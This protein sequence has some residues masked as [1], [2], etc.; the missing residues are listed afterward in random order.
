MSRIIGKAEESLGRITDN[1]RL[2][3]KGHERRTHA[4]NKKMIAKDPATYLNRVNDGVKDNYDAGPADNKH[5]YQAVGRQD[6]PQHYPDT[7]QPRHTPSRNI[8]GHKEALTSYPTEE[9]SY[10]AQH[11]P[12]VDRAEYTPR[13]DIADQKETTPGY[14][15]NGQTHGAQDRPDA[16]NSQYLPNHNIA[17]HQEA[18]EGYPVRDQKHDVQHHLG[19]NKPEQ[20]RSHDFADQGGVSKGY[21]TGGQSY[22]MQR[23]TDAGPAPYTEDYAT[24]NQHNEVPASSMP[25]PPPGDVYEV[26]KDAAGYNIGGNHGYPAANQHVE[27]HNQRNSEQFQQNRGRSSASD[28]ESSG[29]SKGVGIGYELKGSAQRKLGNATGNP[30]MEQRGRERQERGK[31]ERMLAEQ[32]RSQQYSV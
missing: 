10:G 26:Q 20:T 9:Q 3:A 6:V 27:S 14:P 29:I 30:D 24:Q 25:N 7:G 23:H 21:S 18:S 1:P 13:R 31:H 28:R 15:T 11:R 17:G 32:G 5:R 4:H 12:E 8:A 16:L 2:E 22:G 19:T